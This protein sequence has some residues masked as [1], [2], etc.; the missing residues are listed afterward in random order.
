MMYLISIFFLLLTAIT[1]PILRNEI[2]T[3]DRN[4][5]QHKQCLVGA[6]CLLPGKELSALLRVMSVSFIESQMKGVKKGRGKF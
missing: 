1:I 6:A 4:D 2:K 5:Q 3:K